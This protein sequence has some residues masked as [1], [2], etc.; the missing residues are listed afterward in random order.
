MGVNQPAV[1]DIRNNCEQEPAC[2]LFAHAKQPRQLSAAGKQFG[3][4]TLGADIYQQ[5]TTS[6]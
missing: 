1:V 3:Y 4:A 6:V 5:T 2:L